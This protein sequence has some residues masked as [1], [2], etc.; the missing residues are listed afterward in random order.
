VD[1]E[2]KTQPSMVRRR[3]LLVDDDEDLLDTTAALL[4]DEFEVLTAPSGE[5]GLVVLQQRSV[6]VVCADYKMSGMNGL[7]LLHAVSE[8]WRGT[9]GV[10]ITGMRES[11]GRSVIGDEAVF[12]VVYKPYEAKRLLETVR[13]AARAVSMTSAA[14]NFA[15]R[16]GRLKESGRGG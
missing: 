3:I 15:N 1:H 4:E 16:S 9:A 7:D 13:D 11:L 6:S 14:T 10:L 12:A 2:P 8:R 5:R